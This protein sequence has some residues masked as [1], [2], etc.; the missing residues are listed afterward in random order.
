MCHFSIKKLKKI[1]KIKKKKLKF[2]FYYSTTPPIGKRTVTGGV[3]RRSG[4]NWEITPPQTTILLK[5]K[6]NK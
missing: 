1:K 6:I 5:K 2:I 4:C 3:S